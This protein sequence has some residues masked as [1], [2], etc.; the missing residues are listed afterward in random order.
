MA[1]STEGGKTFGTHNDEMPKVF[2]ITKKGKRKTI[3][4]KDYA[5]SAF[6]IKGMK[7]SE[8][9]T[10]FCVSG[11]I[12][13]LD[14]GIHRIATFMRE[15]YDYL[16]IEFKSNYFKGK[17]TIQFEIV[18]IESSEEGRLIGGY[19]IVT[20]NIVQ[21]PAYRNLQIWKT[22]RGYKDIKISDIV[23]DVFD[24]YL[25]KGSSVKYKDN[26]EKGPTIEPTK[27]KMESFCNPFWC[28][29]RTINYLKK[30]AM[31]AT[32]AGFFCFFDM[33][34]VFNFRSLMHLMNN[35][36]THTLELTDLRNS[37]LEE[38]IQDSKFVVRDYYANMVQKQYYKIGLAGAAVERFNWFHKKH[39]TH[40]RG[41]SDRPLS[42]QGPNA[43]FEKP[44]DV[45]NMYGQHDLIGYRWA[46][47]TDFAKAVVY[48]RM[49]TAIAAQ[50]RTHVLIN[51]IIDLGSG[52]TIKI[53][54]K[55]QGTNAN[56]EELKGYWFIRAVDHIW[57]QPKPY[58]QK[59][60]LMRRAE[61]QH[62]GPG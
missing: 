52:D 3:G 35:G 21:F 26:N 48:N 55:S 49:M 15:G 1:E 45:N 46:K 14:H 41:Y 5:L 12:M 23:K 47:T 16:E 44:E 27:L 22:S 54:N 30:Y 58:T 7:L 24:R 62:L 11:Y 40:K 42:T 57:T 53:N 4:G 38:A 60:H 31:T 43:I 20:I 59:L 33:N 8:G 34:N 2:P 18:N 32:S 39:Y 51:G 9:I 13:F 6:D 19:D 37:T 61:M 28:P 36:K 56:I 50:V 25:N 10:D 29:Y 17:K